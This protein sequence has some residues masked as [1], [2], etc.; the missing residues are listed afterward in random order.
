[1]LNIFRPFFR[2]PTVMISEFIIVDKQWSLKNAAYNYKIE[3]LNIEISEKNNSR[4]CYH[5]CQLKII[6][7]QFNL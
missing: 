4:I 3:I 7:S 6:Q 5:V 2:R 1:M